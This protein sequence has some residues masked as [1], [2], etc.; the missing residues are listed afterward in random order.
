MRSAHSLVVDRAL[1]GSGDAIATCTGFS[2]D[3]QDRR[4]AYGDSA[5]FQEDPH[6]RDYFLFFEYFNGDN[7]VGIG[8]SHQTGWTGLIA[9]L[10]QQ[11]GGKYDNPHNS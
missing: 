3:G 11:T 2:G 1:L 9:K 8:A 4:P 10:L 5:K 7:G 6:W